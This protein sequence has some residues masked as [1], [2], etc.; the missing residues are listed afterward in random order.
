MLTN[1]AG[2][3]SSSF[4]LTHDLGFYLTV[5][6]TRQMCRERGSGEDM[7]GRERGKEDAWQVRDG[8]DLREAFL[9][10][11]TGSFKL[12]L[13]LQRQVIR[14]HWIFPSSF[15]QASPQ[16]ELGTPWASC[17]PTQR[18]CTQNWHFF[19]SVLIIISVTHICRLGIPGLHICWV[20][21]STELATQ[22]LLN[23][24]PR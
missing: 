17:H 20:G 11:I 13:P 18:F 8:E 23:L 10:P 24:V 5:E 21:S 9:C 6:G 22:T 4:F 2:I 1:K 16:P 7:K 3:S 19:K 15:S 14:L 12:F